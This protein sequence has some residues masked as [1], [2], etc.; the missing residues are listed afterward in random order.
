MHMD[1][2]INIWRYACIWTDKQIDRGKVNWTREVDRCIQVNK[3]MDRYKDRQIDR[4]TRK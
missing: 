3:Y 4:K 2:Q 1:R